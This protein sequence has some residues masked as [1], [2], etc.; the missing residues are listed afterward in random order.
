MEITPPG[1]A[2]S[3]LDTDLSVDFAAPL[4]YIEPEYKPRGA[5]NG[6]S[7]KEKFVIDTSRKEEVEAR[8]SGSSTPVGGAGPGKEGSWEA[9]KG[10]GASLGGKRVKGKGV[11][12]K[13]IEAVD[14][15]SRLMRTE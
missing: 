9:F 1:Q 10:T 7:M 12:A 6:P 4:G 3:V 14:A 2:I 11:K 15:D 5:I 13:G 8:G